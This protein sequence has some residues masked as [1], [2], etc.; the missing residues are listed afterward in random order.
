MKEQVLHRERAHLK[1]PD[2]SLVWNEL[3]TKKL[4]M[5]LSR[6]NEISGGFEKIVPVSESFWSN[7][8]F[9]RMTDLTAWLWGWNVRVNGIHHTL[10]TPYLFHSFSDFFVYVVTTLVISKKPEAMCQLFDKHGYPVCV[11]QVGHHRAQQIDWQ[12][13]LQTAEKENTEHFHLLFLHINP[14]T[15]HNSSNRSDEGLT[16]ETSAFFPFTVA[17]LRFQLSC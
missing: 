17:S 6:L 7:L 15:T 8:K 16:L 10:R 1:V 2:W 4:P 11:V 13:V 3:L 12:S 14:H 5:F 9:L